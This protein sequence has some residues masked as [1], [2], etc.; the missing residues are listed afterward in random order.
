[1]SVQTCAQCGTIVPAGAGFCPHCGRPASEVI[2]GAA[3]VVTAAPAT[4]GRPAALPPSGTFDIESLLAGA[5]GSGYQIRGLVG[6]GGFADVYE[7]WDQGLSRR[8]AV[9]VLRPD[10]AWTQGMLSRF[11]EE[12]RILASL[13]HPNILPI[14]FV[15]EGQ[16]LTYYVMPYIE[17]QSLGSYLPPTGRSRSSARSR[18]RSRFSRRSRTPTRRA[19]CT[20]TSSPTTS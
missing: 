6:R 18:S 4:S 5:L 13:N 3:A 15:G 2:G 12:C 19:C 20:G 16:G 8:L 17:G 9:K 1:M 14:H 11:K 7:V 10:V